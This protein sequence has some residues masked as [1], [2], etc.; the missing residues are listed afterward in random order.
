[1]ATTLRAALFLPPKALRPP[2]VQPAGA[3]AVVGWTIPH[4]PLEHPMPCLYSTDQS[5]SS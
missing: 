3:K 4:A 2:S 5:V 1:M